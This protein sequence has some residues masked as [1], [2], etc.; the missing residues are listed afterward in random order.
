V[1]RLPVDVAKVVVLDVEWLERR[2]GR[3]GVLAQEVVEET[4]PRLCVYSGG[5]GDDAVHIEDDSV[6]SVRIDLHAPH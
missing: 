6:E 5:V 2:A 1:S 4:F 3:L